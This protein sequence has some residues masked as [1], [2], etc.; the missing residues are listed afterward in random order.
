MCERV[1]GGWKTFSGRKNGTGTG[2]NTRTNTWLLLV[3]LL[4]LL[5]LLVIPASGRNVYGVFMFR[6]IM[7]PYL[8]F[9]PRRPRNEKKGQTC[10]ISERTHCKCNVLLNGN[11]SDSFMVA[12][13]GHV[14]VICSVF[15]WPGPFLVGHVMVSTISCFSAKILFLYYIYYIFYGCWWAYCYYVVWHGTNLNC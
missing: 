11:S 9:L 12:L 10:R 14:W 15:C 6:Q 2:R 8:L 3:L 13:V 7:S 1:V 4:L 5:L